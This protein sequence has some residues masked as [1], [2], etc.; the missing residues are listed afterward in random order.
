[1]GEMKKYYLYKTKY[2]KLPRVVKFSVRTNTV[3]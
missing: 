2:K 1:M 3:L